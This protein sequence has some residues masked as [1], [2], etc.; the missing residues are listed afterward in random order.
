MVVKCI[1][2]HNGRKIIFQL[3]YISFIGQNLIWYK[4][5]RNKKNADS[6]MNTLV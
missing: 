2:A 3:N 4:N 5:F 6:M 1:Y